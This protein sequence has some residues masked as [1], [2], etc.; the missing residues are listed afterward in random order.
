MLTSVS[1]AQNKEPFEDVAYDI[2]KDSISMRTVLGYGQVPKFANYLKDRFLNG[3]FSE[4]DIIQIPHEE[5]MAMIVRYRGDGRSGKKP[6]L[7]SSH[8]DV[9]EALPEDWERDPYTLIEEGGMFYGRGVLDTKLSVATITATLLRLKAEGFMPSR[10]IILVLSG[11]EETSM[12]TTRIITQQHRDL[13]DADFAIIADAWDGRLDDSGKAISYSIIAA[14]KFPNGIEITARNPGGHGAR[15]RKDNAIYDLSEAMM[16]ISRHEFPVR[17]NELTLTFFEKAAKL[18]GGELG[19][20]MTA[21]SKNPQDTGAI[22]VLRASPQYVGMIGTTCIAT[23]LDAGHASNA[24]PQTA[25]ATIDCRLFPEVSIEDTIET[26]KKVIG[27]DELEFKVILSLIDAP[28][29]PLREDV[30]GAVE[31]AIHAEYPD[32]PIVPAMTVGATEGRYFRAAGIPSYALTG[33]FIKASDAAGAHGLNER[34]PVQV[35]PL[36]MRLW[37]SLLTDLAG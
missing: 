17:Y 34:V 9:V 1:F 26:L 14:E 23:M 24:L 33:N 30:L 16:N 13:I 6:I 8:M 5:T 28:A 37:Y 19:A 35:L 10:D 3:G 31:R 2:F 25:T 15:P 11:D 4:D 29:S 27:N 18:A 22:K 32:V 21:F 20:A 36:S 7:L 12:N